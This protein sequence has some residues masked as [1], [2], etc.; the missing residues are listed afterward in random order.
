MLVFWNCMKWCHIIGQYDS[1]EINSCCTLRI[2]H[3]W[4]HSSTHHC[5]CLQPRTTAHALS[6]VVLATLWHS[7][8][9]SSLMFVYFDIL[10]VS[11]IDLLS[12][13]APY[14]TMYS[15]CIGII[16][17]HFFI[18]LSAKPSI[19][20]ILLLPFNT[21]E[22]I[23]ESSSSVMLWRWQCSCC[24]LAAHI[25]YCKSPRIVVGETFLLLAE[26]SSD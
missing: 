26:T 22:V 20:V 11:Y 5:I 17:F 14:Q 12:Q 10:L 13:L 24:V 18:W 6:K 23:L 15:Q 21:T 4:R 25:V 8:L 1:V 7:S 2:W 9:C 19:F 3:W 16:T